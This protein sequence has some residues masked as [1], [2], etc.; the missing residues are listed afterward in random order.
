MRGPRDQSVSASARMMAP[1]TST[2]STRTSGRS[3]S[4]RRAGRSSQLR[5]V[6]FRRGSSARALPEPALGGSLDELLPFLNIAEPAEQQLALAW[7]VFACMPGGAFPPLLLGGQQDAGKSTVARVL[8]ALIDPDDT[9]LTPAPR[10]DEDLI[11]VASDNWLPIFDNLSHLEPW[12]SDALCRL[13]DGTGLKRRAR[14]TDSSVAVVH[15]KRPV[16]LTGI[17]ELATRG[18][19]LNRALIL[20]LPPLDDAHRRPDTELWVA[21]EEARPRM[22]GALYGT[23]SGVL[24]ELPNVGLPRLPRMGDFARVGVAVER[25]LAWPRGSFLANYAENRATGEELALEF[26]PIVESLCRLAQERGDWEGSMSELLQELEQ[27]APEEARRSRRW[28]GAAHILSGQLDRL[29]PGLQQRHVTVKHGRSRQGSWASIRDDSNGMPESYV[30]SVTS[31]TEAS[32]GGAPVGPV[33]VGD[34]GDASRV[35]G[36]SHDLNAALSVAGAHTPS[37]NGLRD[38]RDAGDASL[39]LNPQEEREEKREGNGGADDL[40]AAYVR[41]ALA[42]GRLNGLPLALAP[43]VTAEDAAKTARVL[44]AELGRPG[45]VG[46]TARDHVERLADALRAAEGAS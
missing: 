38:P 24:A 16:I 27:R 37:P 5:P 10:D 33:T 30:G 14:Y 39:L 12:L 9:P 4:P 25:V 35:K 28:P 44:L 22:L 23:L 13:G 45:Q 41:A 34:A 1:S 6:R 15:A 31:V 8:R 21:L 42:S 29:A 7:L 11:V 43:G 26:Y 2:F 20:R 3:R 40:T 32:P 17:G 19:L 18:N 46:V 36:A